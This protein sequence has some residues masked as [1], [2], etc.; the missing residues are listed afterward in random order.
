MTPAKRDV[1]ELIQAAERQ[2]PP[3]QRSSAGG[4]QALR[5]P[6]VWALLLLA[7]ALG[8]LSVRAPAAGAPGA[9]PGDG[10]PAQ[11]GPPAPPGLSPTERLGGAPLEAMERALFD[12]QNRYAVLAMTYAQTPRN[13]Q[14]AQDT[15]SYLASLDLPVA[16]PQAVGERIFI[17]L[18]ASPERAD[19]EALLARV[20]ATPDATGRRGTFAS[21][22]CVSIDETLRRR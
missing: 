6:L 21:A 12:P 8:R 19:L 13:R 7:F 18:G 10:P 4:F 20:R 2:R 5:Q 14:W 22:Y 9:D 17:L 16:P 1:H 3:T 11:P 15:V